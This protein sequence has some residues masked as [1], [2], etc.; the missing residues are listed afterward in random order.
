MTTF[1]L[2]RADGSGMEE[3]PDFV[4]EADRIAYEPGFVVFRNNDLR[5]LRSVRAD[6]LTDIR[7]L[8]EIC[9]ALKGARGTRTEELCTF[10]EHEGKH[11]WETACGARLTHST[12]GVLECTEMMNHP[13][14]VPHSWIDE[15]A[16]GERHEYGLYIE[17]LL[18]KR[19][20]EGA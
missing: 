10:R 11:S 13:E 2:W 3:Y 7:Q 1:Q 5:I 4:V 17:G 9:G 6:S 16:P 8:P 18:L 15:L 14:W 20:R 12:K 19:E